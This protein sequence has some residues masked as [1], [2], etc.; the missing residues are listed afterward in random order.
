MANGWYWGSNPW[1]DVEGKTVIDIA[2]SD[3]EEEVL[4]ITFKDGEAAYIGTEGDCCSRSWWSD[5]IGKKSAMGGKITGVRVLELPEP[6]DSRRYSEED[7]VYGYSLDTDRGSV[8]L[9]FRNAS[10]GYYGGSCYRMEDPPIS[11][12]WHFIDTNDWSA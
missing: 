9:A 10:N 7:K 11:G 8:T 12:G 6:K 1:E 4:C 5:V 3:P 2:V